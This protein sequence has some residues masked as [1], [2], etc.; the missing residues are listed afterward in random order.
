MIDSEDDNEDE[1]DDNYEHR[2]NHKSMSSLTSSGSKTLS[3]H[4]SDNT[5][6]SPVPPE[7]SEIVS[8]KSDD[9]TEIETEEMHGMYNLNN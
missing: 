9:E 6:G 1:D 5:E 3:A 4:I 8:S 7:F 2:S